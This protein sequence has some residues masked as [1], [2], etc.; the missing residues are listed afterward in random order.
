MYSV[1]QRPKL[2]YANLTLVPT[3]TLMGATQQRK[4]SI[5]LSGRAPL[6]LRTA[7]TFTLILTLFPNKIRSNPNPT[8]TVHLVRENGSAPLLDKNSTLLVPLQRSS[9]VC[10]SEAGERGLSQCDTSEDCENVK[11]A[12]GTWTPYCDTAS[13][14]CLP[15]VR[16]WAQTLNLPRKPLSPYLPHPVHPTN[17]KP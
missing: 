13:H 15:E 17:R 5:V 11:N 14:T 6:P 3:L 2:Q 12:C 16:R 9:F 10:E 7:E 8:G 4:G 1:K